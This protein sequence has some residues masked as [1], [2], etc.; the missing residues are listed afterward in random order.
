MVMAKEWVLWAFGF[1]GLRRERDGCR[2]TASIGAV[3]VG[4]GARVRRKTMMRSVERIR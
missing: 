3:A 1:G 2:R 4:G